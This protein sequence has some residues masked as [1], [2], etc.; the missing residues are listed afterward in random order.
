M[1]PDKFQA[2]LV[3]KQGADFQ[4]GF[5]ELT[6]ADLPPGEILVQ[7][8]YSSVNYKDALACLP[9]GKVA[10]KYPLVPGID[11]AGVVV[12]SSDPA[13]QPGQAVLATGFEIGVSQHGG[14]AAYARIPARHTVPLP[15]GL[16]LAEAMALG[17]AGFTAALAL[18]QL[19]RNGLQPGQGP[20]L[21]TGATGGVS[22]VAIALLAGLG[23]EVAAS[24][25]KAEEAAYLR[26]LGATQILSREE[27][28]APSDRPLEK[29][30]WAASV[31]SV[32]GATLAY[33]ARTTRIAGSI[34]AIGL[35][36]GAA[37]NSTVHPFIL[38]GVNLLGINI[39]ACS[40]ELRHTLWHR[41][42]TD[43]KPASLMTTIAR[44]VPLSD[45]PGV[46]E[47]V[48][49]GRIRGRTVI[50]VGDL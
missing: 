2:Y 38:R 37:F 13:F 28:A 6:E 20:V 21:V 44:E 8:A 16:S 39:D 41:L 45:L 24:T 30:R 7:V 25:G 22:S 18:A 4:A 17:T 33:L 5:V 48:L 46:V 27:V 10:R 47:A 43:L 34:A 11:L 12:E 15:E 1:L 14:Y 3:D 19:E 32:G 9:N 49:A 36:G 42:A 26:E 40:M 29:E 50:R 23:Y 31:D 35:T